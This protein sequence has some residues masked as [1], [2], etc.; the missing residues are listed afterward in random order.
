MQAVSNL[1]GNALLHGR[2]RVEV[3]VR[4]TTTTA[5]LEVHN[6][7]PPV[8]E[9]IRDRLFQAFHGIA[10]KGVARSGL[11]LGLFITDRIVHA[12]GGRI[13]VQS[14]EVDGTTFTVRLPIGLGAPFGSVVRQETPDAVLDGAGSSAHPAT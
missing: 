8:P 12:H 1:V 4:G 2:G 14:T 10:H 7:G 9:E 6:G 13:E 11:G 3:R 5:I